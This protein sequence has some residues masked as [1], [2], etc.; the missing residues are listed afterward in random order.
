MV[1]GLNCFHFFDSFL[2]TFPSL[3][4]FI[5]CFYREKITRHLY[6]LQLKDNVH[7][8]G[9]VC[10]EEKCFQLVSYALQADNG[11]YVRCKH[12]VQYFDPREYFPAWVIFFSPY[13]PCSYLIDFHCNCFYTPS[14]S[15]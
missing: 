2:P 6:Y 13:S 12:G 11:N 3:I 4:Y 9:H 14:G 8:Y 15:I 1:I 10:T 7:N 5:L